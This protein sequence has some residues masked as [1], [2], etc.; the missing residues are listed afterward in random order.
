MG[1]VVSLALA[2]ALALLGGCIQAASVTPASVGD[3]AKTA[4]PLVAFR[5][6][7][8]F[9]LPIDYAALKVR[10]SPTGF[11]GGEP[12]IGV[13]KDGTI[14]TV[15]KGDTIPTKDVLAMSSDHGTKWHIMSDIKNGPISLDPWMHVD[16]I[17]DR[18]WNTPLYV[19]CTWAAWSDDKGT[20][21]D[22]NPIAGCGVPAH[23]HQKLTTGAPAKGVQTMGYPDVVYYS[24]NSFRKEGTWI[25]ESY[26]G[27]RTFNVG[28]VVHANS[29]HAGIASPV[30]VAPDGTAYSAKP[31]CDGLDIAVSKDSGKT[32]KVTGHVNDVGIYQALATTVD[33]TTDTENNAYAAYG[34]KDGLIYLTTS[35]DGGEIGRAH[36]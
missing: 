14:F 36:V 10:V 32:W 18:L 9:A 22:A 19:A 16:P 35:H 5:G 8:T 29:C 17:T 7:D 30:A 33:I 2:F 27:G 26:D 34:A 21:W 24:Y 3:L 28:Q 13:T 25:S 6:L 23:D 1:R 12:S 11:N 20:S 4:T 15:V 31:T